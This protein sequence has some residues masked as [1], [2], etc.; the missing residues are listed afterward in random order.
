MKALKYFLVLGSLNLCFAQESSMDELL[1]TYETESKLSKI[2]KIESAGFVT[3]YSRDD[4]E[5]M[6]ARTL[7]DILRTFSIPNIS[8]TATNNSYFMKPSNKSMPN[9]AIR[10]YINDHDMA[11]S[12][13][14]SDAMVWSD[15]SLEFIDHIVVYKTS[16][17]IEFGNEP[18][19]VII[20]LYTK[21][22][23]TEEGGKVRVTADQK[24][25]ASLSTYYAH[26]TKSG[27]SYLL[28]ANKDY[29]EREAYY[30]QAYEL[31]SDNDSENAYANFS[32]KNFEVEL[33]H[34][35]K[36]NNAFLGMG[37]VYT[38]SN[39]KDNKQ[40]NDHD[41]IHMSKKF[42]NDLRV[43]LSYD[44][45]DVDLDYYDD[46]GISA[47]SIGIVSDY[48]V[49]IK[50]SVLSATIEKTFNFKN[51]RLFIGGFYKQKTSD[52]RGSF[53]TNSSNFKNTL[54]IY[55][56]YGENSYSFSESFMF[57]T[58]LK[59]DFYRY[60]KDV[61]SQDML[62]AR[63]GLIKNIDNFQIKAFYTQTYYAIPMAALYSGD[64]NTPLKT[65]TSLDYPEPTLLSL[66]VKYKSRNHELNLKGAMITV[67][68]KVVPDPAVGFRNL[69]NISYN[70]YELDYTYYIGAKNKINASI[71]SGENG[72][73]SEMSPKYGVNIFSFNSCGKFDFYNQLLYKDSYEAY[74]VSMDKSYD[75]T[76]SV[77]YRHTDDLTFGIKGENILDKGLEQAYRNYSSSIPVFD[78]KF[79]IN[80]EYLF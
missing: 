9:S 14:G 76:S 41:Y 63:A 49:D 7:M 74:G 18:G 78:R 58:S 47:G 48:V 70:Q 25:S 12:R 2:S 33:G 5:R 37:S 66:G 44:I 45:I 20:K 51:N 36:N 64:T 67:N 50:D 73:G 19:T 65:D 62:I 1:S 61:K 21:S 15:M 75:F 80:M 30:N 4:L 38:P 8:R 46:G 71:Y 72:E 39:T 42:D 54:N 69:D 13:F 11:A 35:E 57:V 27:F 43:Q 22:P 60:D 3:T 59:G 56:L 32:Y 77:K 52:F 34:Y 6:Q 23:E 28:Y 16:S 26:T 17:S 29:I 10:L 53:D 40:H 24:G 68:N 31:N 79:W 55:S